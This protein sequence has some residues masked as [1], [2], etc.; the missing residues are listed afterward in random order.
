M[1]YCLAHS[2]GTRRGTPFIFEVGVPPFES[3]IPLFP[4]EP[5]RLG[6]TADPLMNCPS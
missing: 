5:A 4:A 3:G 6:A 1:L 2:E